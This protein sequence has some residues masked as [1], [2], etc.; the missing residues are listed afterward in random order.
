MRLGNEKL[1]DPGLYYAKSL[2]S[3]ALVNSKREIQYLLNN[4]PNINLYRRP[5][6]LIPLKDRLSLL[7]NT[8]L[9]TATK[10]VVEERGLEEQFFRCVE[11][12]KIH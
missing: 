8:D 12:L 6:K 5:I 9:L 3:L 4:K 10:K 2:R 1:Y 7:L 11:E